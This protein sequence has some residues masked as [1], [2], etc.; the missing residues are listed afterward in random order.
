MKVTCTLSPVGSVE[1]VE[2]GVGDEPD[3][4]TWQD[5]VTWVCGG[6]TSTHWTPL[7]TVTLWSIPLKVHWTPAVLD[8]MCETLNGFSAESQLELFQASCIP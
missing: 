5:P 6:P 2:G 8:E 3:P 4:C 1:G 7:T